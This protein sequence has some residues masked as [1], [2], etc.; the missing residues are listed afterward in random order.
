ME[1]KLENAN[2]KYEQ[3][4][5]DKEDELRKLCDAKNAL[6]LELFLSKQILEA[7]ERRQLNMSANSAFYANMS[8]YNIAANESF[9][10]C[11]GSSPNDDERGG[12]KRKLELDEASS[13]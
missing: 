10:L 7:E 1:E 5:A 3:L 9:I 6:D 4:M 12:K 13:Y 8:V 2:V 11:D